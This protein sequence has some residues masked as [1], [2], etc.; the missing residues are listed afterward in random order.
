MLRPS[1][2][3]ISSHSLYTFFW[4]KLPLGHACRRHA[5]T[6]CAIHFP[7][8]LSCGMDTRWSTPRK[9]APQSECSCGAPTRC[10]HGGFYAREVLFDRLPR[11]KWNCEY[12][13]LISQL[14]GVACW[15]RC[16]SECWHNSW[17][18]LQTQ[19]PMYWHLYRYM[20]NYVIGRWLILPIIWINFD[21]FDMLISGALIII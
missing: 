13:C 14:V 11:I 19:C 18:L 16:V 8:R 3:W 1:T 17:H 7:L 9:Y 2:I 20:A 6:L 15:G 12:Y 21:G 5:K 10:A 4:V